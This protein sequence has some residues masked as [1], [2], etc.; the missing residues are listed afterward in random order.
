M[1]DGPTHTN[2]REHEYQNIYRGSINGRVDCGQLDDFAHADAVT[3]VGGA[4][5]NIINA[6]GILESL[7]V[8]HIMVPN[9]PDLGQTPEFNINAPIGTL[10]PGPSLMFNSQLNSAPDLLKTT[11]SEVMIYGV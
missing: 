1:V 9:M 3:G 8:Q 5:N 7:G 2:H 10:F 11:F 6:L 4:V